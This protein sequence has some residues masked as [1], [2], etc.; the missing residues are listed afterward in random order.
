MEEK[1]EFN[2][3]VNGNY[4]LA[5]SQKGKKIIFR[6]QKSGGVIPENYELICNS[7]YMINLSK[8]FTICPDISDIYQALIIDLKNYS[9]QIKVEFDNEKAII[10]FILDYKI[11]NK[12]ET[13]PIYLYKKKIVSIQSY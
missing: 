6:L 8:L 1:T 4:L 13:K 5:C 7:K 2:Q 10:T 11:Y 3:K 9:E 12:K